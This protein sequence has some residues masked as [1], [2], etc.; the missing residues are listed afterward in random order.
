[1]A[2]EHPGEQEMPQG[3][4]GPP[5]DLEHEHHLVDVR[6]P[7]AGTALPLWWLTGRPATSHAR[8]NGS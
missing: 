8:H 5:G 6:V 4:M 1:M 3:A 7:R 2:F